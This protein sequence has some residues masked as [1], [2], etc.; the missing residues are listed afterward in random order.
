MFNSAATSTLDAYNAYVFSKAAANPRIKVMDIASVYNAVNGYNATPYTSVDKT[1]P[2][3]VGGQQYLA[4]TEAAALRAVTA[5][6]SIMPSS[7]AMT[8]NLNTNWD[9]AGTTGTIGSGVSAGGQVATGWTVTNASGATVTVSKGTTADGATAQ[10]ITVSGT[11]TADPTTTGDIRLSRST[12]TLNFTAND[13]VTGVVTLE[14]ASAN[15]GNPVGLATALVQGGSAFNWMSKT[16][17][18]ANSGTTPQTLGAGPIPLAFSGVARAAPQ[19]FISGGASLTIETTF[20]CVKDANADFVIK[21]SRFNVLKMESTAYA[22]PYNASGLSPAP[23]A[24]ISIAVSP[25][26]QVGNSITLAKRAVFSGGGLTRAL[27]WQLSDGVGG[28]T[29]IS[30]ATGTSYTIQAGDSG[31]QI[32]VQ[33]T[34]TNT[35]GS[36]TATSAST[37]TVP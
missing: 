20:R 23:Y 19:S 22:A 28:W 27:Q 4:M 17:D 8:G 6:G 13:I 16:Q 34:A 15:G 10:V 12:G 5:S 31:H 26:A 25:V 24:N 36:A 32:R 1:H 35:M 2:S 37:A 14:V 3:A 11:C 18:A 33:E 21:V 7:G 29:D 9:L 30:G